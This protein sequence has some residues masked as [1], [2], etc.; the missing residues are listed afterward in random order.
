MSIR[1]IVA[2]DPPPGPRGPYRK[3]TLTRARILHAA[4]EVLGESGY[5][6]CS[7]RAVAKRAQISQAGLLHHF[8][9]KVALLSAVFEAR[10]HRAQEEIPTDSPGTDQLKAIVR[11]AR[12]SATQPAE[13]GLYTVLTAEATRPEHPGHDYMRRRY[14]WVEDEVAGAFSKVA[15]AGWLQPWAEPAIVASQ[16]IALWDGLQIQ[17]LLHVGEVDVSTRLEQ[18]INLHLVRPLA[19]LNR[20]D[21]LEDDNQT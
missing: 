20:D 9:S 6:G 17:W 13:I 10:D 2:N 8:P 16:L 19:Q 15:E 7:M 1:P 3:T 4:V 12:I 18:F 14:I 21:A 11:F 5:A